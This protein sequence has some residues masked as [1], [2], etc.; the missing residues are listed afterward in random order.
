MNAPR[1]PTLVI[2]MQIVLTLL[3]H[4]HVNVAVV[5]LAMVTPVRVRILSNFKN[6]CVPLQLEPKIP[7]MN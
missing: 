5:I 3:V 2:K 1:V 7:N 4:T 6:L